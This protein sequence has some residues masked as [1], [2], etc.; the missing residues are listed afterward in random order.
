M[1]E[2]S[3]SR[4]RMC[5]PCVSQLSSND[6]EGA[7]VARSLELR[8][9]SFQLDAGVGGCELPVGFGVALVAVVLPC[10]DF[11]GED[12]LVGDAAI[13]TLRGENAEFGFGQIE[14][15]TAQCDREHPPAPGAPSADSRRA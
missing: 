6:A 13:E 1:W 3:R 7:L 12:L 9:Q 10:G 8:V 15:T 5:S 14:P 2:P 11:A 4:R